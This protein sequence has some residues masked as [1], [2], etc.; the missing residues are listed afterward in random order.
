LLR[1]AETYERGIARTLGRGG[2][3]D[4]NAAIVGGLLGARGLWHRVQ[5][6]SR[7]A[8]CLRSMWGRN[9]RS[10]ASSTCCAAATA[11]PTYSG[12]SGCGWAAS[13][14]LGE[15]ADRQGAQAHRLA[16]A[17]V[18]QCLALLSGA[19]YWLGWP[20]FAK[21]ARATGLDAMWSEG[22]IWVGWQASNSMWA[23]A[24]CE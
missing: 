1:E 14:P 3:T 10:N 13:L 6:G 23:A 21:A 20:V 15:A 9:K 11:T 12:P 19:A 24:C 17:C 2:D 5:W 7:D 22:Y 18:L 8:A 16:V 4:T